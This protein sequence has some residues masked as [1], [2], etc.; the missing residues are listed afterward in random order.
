MVSENCSQ[1]YIARFFWPSVYKK[2]RQLRAL[3][4]YH[5]SS[6]MVT[7]PILTQLI[8][9]AANHV[10][11]DAFLS[12]VCLPCPLPLHSLTTNCCVTQ[13]LLSIHFWLC[14]HFPHYQ[15]CKAP[16]SSP[17]YVEWKI[18]WRKPLLEFVELDFARMLSIFDKLL[19]LEWG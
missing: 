11:N 9:I 5:S 13:F 14:N 6:C 4:Q 18:S 7:V 1:T 17:L 8:L 15:W 19:K 16:L 12:A 3:E 10:S 2:Q